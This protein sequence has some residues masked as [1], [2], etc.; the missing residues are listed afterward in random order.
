MRRPWGQPRRPDC[1]LW[2]L[3]QLAHRFRASAALGVARRSADCPA[4]MGMPCALCRGL[5]ISTSSVWFP[6]PHSSRRTPQALLALA[7]GD[8]LLRGAI[9]CTV[10]RL[11][12]SLASTHEFYRAGPGCDNQNCFQT[13]PN[14][15]RRAIPLLQR[16]GCSVSIKQDP[17]IQ[18]D[19][20]HTPIYRPD[21]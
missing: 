1:S 8:S 6:T 20:K 4:E 11:A 10:G 18:S 19:L 9:L 21:M 15:P 17:R 16:S 5:S 2:E 14:V 7:S 3:G 12:A 13:L